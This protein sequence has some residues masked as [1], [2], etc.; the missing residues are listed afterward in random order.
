MAV[1]AFRYFRLYNDCAAIHEAI[2]A[3]LGNLDLSDPKTFTSLPFPSLLQIPSQ[4]F[5]NCKIASRNGTFSTWEQ[6]PIR[7]RDVWFRE[8][9][10]HL[11]AA[12]VYRL[13]REGKHVEAE[14]ICLSA[15]AIKSLTAANPNLGP[16]FDEQ[17]AFA[18]F[19][20]ATG[21]E[22]RLYVP[23]AYNLPTVDGIILLLNRRSKE[24]TV[25]PIQFTPSK[26]HEQ[27]DKE[28]YMKLYMD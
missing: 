2:K 6:K 15:I 12:L 23:A 14:Q 28:F 22:T 16:I 4:R 26:D 25:F 17:L 3:M 9:K 18:G 7:V 11:L 8:I 21:Y 5:T 1:M 19:F 20:S 13:I 24:V 10:S 27:S